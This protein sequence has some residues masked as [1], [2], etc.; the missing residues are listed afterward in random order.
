MAQDTQNKQHKLCH[1]CHLGLILPITSK[2]NYQ[3]QVIPRLFSFVLF[4]PNVYPKDHYLSKIKSKNITNAHTSRFEEEMLSK[5][6]LRWN[7]FKD[8]LT[9]FSKT[10]KNSKSFKPILLIRLNTSIIDIVPGK[11]K[12]CLSE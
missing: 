1:F 2:W 5:A 6:I 4:L 10:Y 12:Q 8:L 9:N 7:F 11:I 3:L